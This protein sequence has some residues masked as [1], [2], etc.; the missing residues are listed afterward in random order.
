MNKT[1]SRQ[2]RQEMH[3][4]IQDK[5]QSGSWKDKNQLL[6]GFITATDYERKYAI[7]LLTGKTIKGATTSKKRGKPAYY[8]E[9]V[10]RVLEMLWH[11]GN[12]ICSKRLVPFLPELIATLER[13]GH[14]QMTEAVK[15]RV[16]SIS[17]A[18]LDRVL[19]KKRIKQQAGLSTTPPGTLLKHPI[20][21][22]TFADWNETMPGFFEIDWVAHCGET[23]K[24]VFLNT[25][26]MTD[27][28]T[29]WTECIALIRKSADDVMLGLKTASQ[30]LPF[31]V[32]GCDVDNVL[33]LESSFFSTKSSCATKITIF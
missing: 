4:R 6:N 16:L 19:R 14:L 2:A 9:A 22:R 11:V 1:M 23:T 21:V 13:H 32:L 15:S 20:K 28:V 26:V 3:A 18:T 24:G 10:I 25:L 27:S 5:Y 29:T 33:T 17:P 30:W 31:T 8:D 7:K 12:Q